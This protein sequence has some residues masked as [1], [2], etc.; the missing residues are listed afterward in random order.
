MPP[1][2]TAQR[3]RRGFGSA[4]DLPALIRPL[5][6][7]Q[8]QRPKRPRLLP[9]FPAIV[10]FV[11][12]HR[13]ATGEQVQWRFPELLNSPKTKDNHLA[14]LVQL[15]FLAVAPVRSTSPNFPY[16]YS[17]TTKGVRLIAD[18]YREHGLTWAGA[19]T[20]TVKAQ[21]MALVSILHEVLL[22]E[23]DLAVWRTQQGIGSIKRLMMERRYFRC[24]RQLQFYEG[25][26]TQRLKPDG[27]FL[28]RNEETGRL[29]MHFIELDNGTLSAAKT[30]RKYQLYDSWSRSPE[31][32][33]Y[34]G[35]HFAKFGATSSEPNWRLLMI[36]HAKDREG[37]NERRLLDLLAQTLDLPTAMRERIWLTTA[38]KLRN[39]HE[40]KEPLTRPIWLRARDARPWIGEY[41]QFMRKL[42]QEKRHQRF[43]AQRKFVAEWL[44]DFREHPLF[45]LTASHQAA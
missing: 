19:K 23:F 22:T 42:R 35:E 43:A 12:D 4:W 40:L 32:G 24:D 37:G 45:S 6:L 39:C 9:H 25:G 41:R 1:A 15:G 28:M 5:P 33:K 18:T 26:Q 38:E 11:Y 34:L 30:R 29:L 17:A 8:R 27:G 10:E 31:G 20:E 7:R 36:A 3:K 14:N 13:W 16:V 2:P 21:G 44:S